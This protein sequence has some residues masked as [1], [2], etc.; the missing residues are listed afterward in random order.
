MIS[1]AA[2]LWIYLDARSALQDGR[3]AIVEGPVGNFHPQPYGGHDT[4]RFD[5]GGRHFE[6]SDYGSTPGFNTTQSHGGPVHA[7]EYVRITHY[8]GAILRLEDRQ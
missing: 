6:Y 5:V 2:N 8:R 1:F 4:E 3:A 7:G